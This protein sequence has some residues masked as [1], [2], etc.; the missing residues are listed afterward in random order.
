[1]GVKVETDLFCDGAGSRLFRCWWSLCLSGHV[2]W[3]A[4]RH[5]DVWWV[6]CDGFSA[7]LLGFLHVLRAAL[8]RDDC[9]VKRN[10]TPRHVKLKGVRT[11]GIFAPGRGMVLELRTRVRSIRQSEDRVRTAA[12]LQPPPGRR[13][14]SV[15]ATRTH[16]SF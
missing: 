4:L 2:K 16:R 11:E 5:R 10:A 15:R 9:K 8:L 14:Q 13:D 3:V 7:V 6:I 1:M 12:R